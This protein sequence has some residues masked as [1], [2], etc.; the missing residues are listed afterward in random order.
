MLGRILAGAFVFFSLQMQN[1][2]EKAFGCNERTSWDSV[3]LK[4]TFSYSQ[5]SF[6]G[7][8]LFLLLNEELFRQQCEIKALFSP[9]FAALLFFNVKLVVL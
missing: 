7:L 4:H 5:K 9:S 6:F 8:F 2:D 3:H 1:A